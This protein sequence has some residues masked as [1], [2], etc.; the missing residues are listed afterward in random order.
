MGL[1]RESG[2]AGRVKRK[3]RYRVKAMSDYL[4]GQDLLTFEYDS[5]LEIVT[6]EEQ[7]LA[8]ASSGIITLNRPDKIRAT[9]DAGF[10]DVEML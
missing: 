6:E 1:D 7:K 2:S 9:R 4:A 5:T 8:L 3:R 10:A